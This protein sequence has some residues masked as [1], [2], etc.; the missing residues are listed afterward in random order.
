MNTRYSAD[1][2]KCRAVSGAVIQRASSVWAGYASAAPEHLVDSVEYATR[3]TYVC[4]ATRQ[5]M[6]VAA[7]LAAILPPIPA[8]MAVVS[9]SVPAA[10]S[11]AANVVVTNAHPCA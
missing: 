3:I 9:P 5:A 2:E 6:A 8:K 7:L 4:P 11:C 1:Q 10:D